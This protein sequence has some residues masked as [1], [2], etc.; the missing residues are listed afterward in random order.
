MVPPWS[1]SPQCAEHGIEKANVLVNEQ[2][3]KHEGTCANW[4]LDSGWVQYVSGKKLDGVQSSN[5][6]RELEAVKGSGLPTVRHVIASY[7]G[8]GS[9]YGAGVQTYIT[10][11]PISATQGRQRYSKCKFATSQCAT[12]PQFPANKWPQNGT[13]C[14]YGVFFFC[15]AIYTRH[16]PADAIAPEIIGRPVLAVVR[17]MALLDRSVVWFKGIA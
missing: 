12:W 13:Y 16:A 7:S 11:H 6:K 9:I 15:F 2:T 17:C 8:G 10:P 5:F 4:K 14:I 1:P 3:R